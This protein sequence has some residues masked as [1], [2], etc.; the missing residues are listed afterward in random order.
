MVQGKLGGYIRNV[1]S[2]C[3]H[4]EPKRSGLEFTLKG[5]TLKGFILKGTSDQH[6]TFCGDGKPVDVGSGCP[7]P[8]PKRSGVR[9]HP[10]GNLRPTFFILW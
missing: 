10:E 4:P 2:G 3:P 7:H 8:E 9:V 6:S 1:G 5:F